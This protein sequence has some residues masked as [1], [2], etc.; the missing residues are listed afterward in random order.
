MS[1]C[2]QNPAAASGFRQELLLLDGK[3]HD[4]PVLRDAAITVVFF[5]QGLSSIL[6]GKV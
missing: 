1:Y 5:L 3:P 4:P 6:L 2:L